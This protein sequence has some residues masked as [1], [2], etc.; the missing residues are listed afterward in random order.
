MNFLE[1]VDRGELEGFEIYSKASKDLEAQ[2]VADRQADE[3][4][5]LLKREHMDVGVKKSIVYEKA[6]STGSSLLVK[7]VY[8]NSIAGFD[9]LGEKGKR[10]EDVAREVLKQFKSF[11]DSEAAVDR[12]M[13]DQLM[14]F[15]ALIGGRISIPE[16]T[17]H[18]QTNL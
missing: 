13:S 12:Y 15:V 14:I 8:E 11:Q 10:S 3:A 5:K 4:A 18:V 16:V 2:G 7:A 1:L 17:D 6:A 9:A